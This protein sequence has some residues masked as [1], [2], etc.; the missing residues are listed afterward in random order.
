MT[1]KPPAHGTEA[2]RWGTKLRPPCTC[3][4]CLNGSRR[5]RK[6]Y[7]VRYSRGES[8]LAP[9]APVSVHLKKVI[10]SGRTIS[11]IAKESG[12][13]W[14]TVHD[15]LNMRRPKMLQSKAEKLLAVSAAPDESALVD[16]TGT[17]RRLRALVA[18]GHPQSVIAGEVGC[19]YTYIS[20]L[21]HGQRATVTIAL[22]RSVQ[23]AYAKLSMTVGKSSEARARAAAYGWHGPLAWD[24]DTIDDP[25]AVPQVDAIEPIATEGGNLAARWLMGESVV[26]D[27]QAHREV[28][29]YLF[30]WT[31]DTAEDIAERLDMTPEAA[32]R[33]WHRLKEKAA[34]E[35]RRVWRRVYVPRERTLKQNEME[36]TA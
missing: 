34:L 4:T 13:H 26:L 16:S 11:Q 25:K 27:R 36:K 9:T 32:A 14:N 12:V 2:R 35:G 29:R 1:R 3:P 19:A 17:V 31:N 22:E 24:D 10:E 5:F 8:G 28:L 6:V 20:T 18:M 15:A 23:R 30:E 21:T 7:M 33:Q